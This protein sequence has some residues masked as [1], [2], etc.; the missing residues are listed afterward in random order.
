MWRVTIDSLFSSNKTYPGHSGICLVRLRYLQASV[1]YGFSD[2]V[3]DYHLILSGLLRCIKRLTFYEFFFWF[4]Y[5]RWYPETIPFNFYRFFQFLSNSG[6]QMIIILHSSPVARRKR[7]WSSFMIPWS[8]AILQALL[9]LFHSPGGKKFFESPDNLIT[10]KEGS[11]PKIL[12]TS[13]EYL[14]FSDFRS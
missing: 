6:V 8:M 13:S 7:N 14:T 3:T 2:L 1:K 4:F 11:S 9:N 12:E 10:G 5:V